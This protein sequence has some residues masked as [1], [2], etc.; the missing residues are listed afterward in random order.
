[1]FEVRWVLRFKHVIQ[2]DDISIIELFKYLYLS[3]KT[4][5]VNHIF[6]E[7]KHLFDG[8]S[9]PSGFV[10]GLCNLTIAPPANDLLNLIVASDLPLSL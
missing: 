2:F 1:M 6:E 9:A 3:Q 10:N 7:I 8:H 5:S 4:L